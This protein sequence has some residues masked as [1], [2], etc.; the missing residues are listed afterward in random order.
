MGLASMVVSKKLS[1]STCLLLFVLNSM[2]ALYAD[3]MDHYMGIVN[4]IPKMEIKADGQA[5]I[6]AK[7]A[8]NVLVLTC[9]SVAESLKI[10]NDTASRQNMPLFCMPATTILDGPMLHDLVQ[11]TYRDISSQ[12]SDKSKMTVSEVALIGLT[13]AY[14]CSKQL[15]QSDIRMQSAKRLST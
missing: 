13:K 1:Y 6:W 10:A 14:P 7:S 11:Q 3:T 12:E 4:N 9:E 2:L 5:Q 15:Q 8:R